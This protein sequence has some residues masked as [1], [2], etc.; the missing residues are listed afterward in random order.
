MNLKEII[1]IAGHNLSDPGAKHNGLNESDL[2]MEFREL[3]KIA[4][5]FQMNDFKR[6][7]KIKVDDDRLSL[8]TVINWLHSFGG[9]DRLIIDIHFNAFNKAANGTEVVIP[10][11]Y[12]K[13]EIGLG[14][15]ILNT[16]GDVSSIYKRR[17]IPES[18]TARKSLGIMRPK[19]INILIELCFMD[20]ESDMSKYQ[21]HK[22]ELAWEIARNILQYNYE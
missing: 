19:G 17:V 7:Y 2:T 3:L 14:K 1:L 8:S 12:C 22:N 6:N 18:K 16:I 5:E 4:L 10:N 9:E 15:T 20:N 21:L 13:N 11:K